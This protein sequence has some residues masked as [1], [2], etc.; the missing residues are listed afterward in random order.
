MAINETTQ[1][2]INNPGNTKTVTLDIIKNVFAD[3]EGDEAYALVL[4]TTATSKINSGAIA[5]TY[6]R[7]F[8]VGYSK[9]RKVTGPFIIDGTNNQLQVSIDGSA[10]ASVTLT[11]GTGLTPENV[12]ADLQS[13]ISSLAAVGEA[14]EGNL[15]FLNVDVEFIEGR[16]QI[17]SGSV[18]DTYTGSAKS[19][20]AVISGANDASVLLGFNIPIESEA[21]A[22]KTPAE[23]VTISGYT[24]GGTTLALET[25]TG[26]NAGEAFTITDGTNR[27]YFIATTVT[28]GAAELTID[29]AALSN[30]Y[31]A[32]SVVQ[33]IFERDPD[34]TIASTIRT[35][36][37]IMKF[38]LKNVVN[39]IDF[40][41]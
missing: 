33:R 5:N 20:V 23:S 29:A 13:Q 16:F 40:T 31:S 38:S 39:Q 19:S 11:S 1:D 24:A 15:A 4:T 17:L 30:N 3:S 32:G 27:E 36:D 14:Q 10:F 34:L 12:V 25:V 21:L 18:S 28:S 41:V 8:K 6:L 35:V 7:D 22:S 2:A 26:L 9:S 37:D